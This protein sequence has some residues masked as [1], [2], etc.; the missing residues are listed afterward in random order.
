[1][2]AAQTGSGKTLAF[3]VPAVELL[4]RLNFLP[5][6]G[7]LSFNTAMYGVLPASML[8]QKLRLYILQLKC[9]LFDLLQVRV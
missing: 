2:G 1:M 6:N 7:L 3:L 9:A 5:R 4:H 8:D